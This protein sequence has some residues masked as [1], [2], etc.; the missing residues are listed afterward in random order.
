VGG[1]G[2]A[3]VAKVIGGR[4]V[5]KLTLPLHVGQEIREGRELRRADCGVTRLP[6]VELLGRL[7][8]VI[9]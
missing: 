2:S 9:S 4:R 7:V 8:F 1:L 5:I 3:A 6:Q